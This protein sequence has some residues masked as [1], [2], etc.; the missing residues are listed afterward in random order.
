MIDRW[1]AFCLFCIHAIPAFS[2][3]DAF[4]GSRRGGSQLVVSLDGSD[5]E[6]ADNRYIFESILNF[7]FSVRHGTFSNLF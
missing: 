3:D 5:D 1:L 4:R 2:A 6:D 7:L